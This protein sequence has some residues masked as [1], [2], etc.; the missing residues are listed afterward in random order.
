MSDRRFERPL[1]AAVI[2]LG[3]IAS[4]LEDDP[5]RE[6][7]CTHAGALASMRECT[8]AGGM[9]NDAERRRLFS[10]RWEAPVFPE[11]REMIRATRPHMVVVATHPDSHE[12][13][14][15]LA[16]EEGVAVAVC[17]KPLAHTVASA[18]RILGIE[19]SG[20]IRIV[21]NHERRFSRDYQLV[22]E[23]VMGDR[24]GSLLGVGATLFF[25][26]TT[27]HDRMLLH[28]GTHLVDAIHFL[29]GDFL[30]ITGRSG[31]LRANR[32]SLFLRGTLQR[33]AVPVQ[34]EV[35]SGRDYLHLEI[36]LTFVS[37]RIR[38]GNGIFDWEK[39]GE[40]PWY[41]GYRSLLS[42]NRTVPHPTDYFTGMMRE[43]IRLLDEEEA[44][45]LSSA[46]DAF[47][48]MRV[49]AEARFPNPVL[50]FFRRG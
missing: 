12:E 34:I 10:E 15:R 32:S 23:A 39:S 21:V 26:R 31:P 50:R 49:I 40:S 33:R 42:M 20:R 45:S 37:G 27:R 6:K 9:D 25:G 14:V 30:T 22:R 41:S 13:Y 46:R 18:R 1:R 19:D 7:P 5:R 43:A 2:G 11:A 44:V 35:G 28:D 4:L 3:R 16:V 29:T 24:F 8:I 38:I 17:E 36:E 48:V 47:A